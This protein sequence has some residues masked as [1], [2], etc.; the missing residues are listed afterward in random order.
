[1]RTEKN[2][3]NFFFGNQIKGGVFVKNS[4]RF[5]FR[6]ILAL[7]LV[8]AQLTGLTPGMLVM[9]QET[10]TPT[11]AE[12]VQS[13]TALP[14]DTPALTDADAASAPAQNEAAAELTTLPE[15]P[16]TLL[17]GP[18]GGPPSG[19]PGGGTLLTEGM[20]TEAS[21]V[22]ITDLS[23][24]F[25]FAVMMPFATQT[26][27]WFSL[28]LA[29]DTVFSITGAASGMSFAYLHAIELYQN[30]SASK[31]DTTFA[32][33]VLT[34]N[35][36]LT[37][38]SYLIKLRASD[39]A[40]VPSGAAIPSIQ[41]MLSFTTSSAAN[42][43]AEGS[44]TNQNPVT[45]A[46][47]SKSYLFTV[48]TYA[49]Q[50]SDLWFAFALPGNGSD[51]ALTI[52][53]SDPA[54]SGSYLHTID[55]YNS[56]GQLLP[57]SFADGSLQAEIATNA[58]YKI[59]LR[60]SSL[61]GTASGGTIPAMDWQ[62]AFQMA[63]ITP[64]VLNDAN[65]ASADNPA[66]IANINK[67]YTFSV[68]TYTTQPTELWL[69]FTI[70]D[71]VSNK[72]LTIT[73]GNGT[74]SSPYL[75]SME[76]R[77][78]SQQVVTGQ[79]SSYGTLFARVSSGTYRLKL[80]SSDYSGTVNGQA[81]PT[82][83]WTL[84]FQ[85]LTTDPN[86]LAEGS[87]TYESPVVIGNIEADYAYCVGDYSV[88]PMKVWFSFTI[89]Q[90]IENQ[91]YAIRNAAGDP[92]SGYSQYAISYLALYDGAK[93]LMAEN[94]GETPLIFAALSSGAYYLAVGNQMRWGP[95]AGG[96]M[97]IQPAS[98]KISFTPA[99]AS[100]TLATGSPVSGSYATAQTVFINVPSGTQVI[101]S[102]SSANPWEDANAVLYHADTGITVSETA[103]LHL[104]AVIYDGETITSYSKPFGLVYLIDEYELTSVRSEVTLNPNGTNYWAIDTT[105]T[106][107]GNYAFSFDMVSTG[108]KN[109]PL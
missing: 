107:A 102:S 109:F 94:T 7:L 55:V 69:S 50:P 38:G 27:L 48:G 108:N 71:G 15:A 89:P 5:G 30:T 92:F 104:A 24:A 16:V 3:V 81:I 18:P 72:E 22:A 82:F 21:P 49:T 88:Q 62:L 74:Y 78:S 57:A 67:T 36:V 79:T 11:Q 86:V 35:A 9:A 93:Q 14:D 2:H 10:E 54:S 59:R 23:K 87:A 43:L 60:S 95:E 100:P 8:L 106:G 19:P 32:S 97:E 73:G 42:V 31:V 44:A 65:P 25:A 103:T 53:G 70:P 6:K 33:G 90:G 41:W 98:C 75:N 61:D 91:N 83:N 47:I 1:M 101:Y 96:F 37:A 29:T 84:Q 39:A 68:G 26:E 52:T 40:G 77:D 20:A 63:V 46:D 80:C 105:A 58:T 4:R 99:L 34:S 13:E 56:S 12:S 45:I 64:P 51:I 28:T 66:V 17:E 76:L 85:L